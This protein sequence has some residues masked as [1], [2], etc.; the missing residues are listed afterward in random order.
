MKIL[1]EYSKESMGNDCWINQYACLI[2]LDFDLYIVTYTDSVTGSWTGNP[3][4][5]S[6]E[7]FTDYNSASKYMQDIIN[8]IR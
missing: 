2:Q 4:T 3:K 1:K 8:K 7:T 5:T 6:A